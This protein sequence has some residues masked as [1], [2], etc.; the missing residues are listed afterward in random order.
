MNRAEARSS[1]KLLVHTLEGE[2]APGADGVIFIHFLVDHEFVV[3][4]EEVVAEE[5]DETL[6]SV[7]LLFRGSPFFKVSNEADSDAGVI[8]VLAADVAAVELLLPAWPNFDFAVA[9]VS[10]VSNHK[11]VSEAVFHSAPA[12]IAII[13]LGVACFN[14]AVVGDDVFPLVRLHLDSL[15]D[16]GG[17]R[18]GRCL[19]H[20]NL[21]GLSSEDFVALQPI[22]TFQSGDARVVLAGDG[23]EGIASANLILQA[24]AQTR[25]WSR[26]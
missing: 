12:V 22:G 7:H 14:R 2:V 8:H 19:A 11:V 26:R 21:Q 24:R 18:E 10:A 6:E 23:R 15:S 1:T 20:W 16:V 4:V 5:V 9:R 25:Q 13:D 17:R 3:S